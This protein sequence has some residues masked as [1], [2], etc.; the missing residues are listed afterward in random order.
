MVPDRRA[1]FA[2]GFRAA[3]LCQQRCQRDSAESVGTAL[4]HFSTVN[5]SRYVVT[6]MHV[7]ILNERK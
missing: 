6:A 3:V 5:G 4:E 2:A 7:R 1:L